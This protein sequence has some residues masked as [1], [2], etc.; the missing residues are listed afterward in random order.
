MTI[1]DQENKKRLL[2]PNVRNFIRSMYGKNANKI[3][4]MDNIFNMDQIA[5]FTW[6]YQSLLW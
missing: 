6:N 1:E 3:E 5:T 4:I 2:S